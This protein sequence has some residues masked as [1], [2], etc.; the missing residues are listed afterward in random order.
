M[1]SLLIFCH[2]FMKYLRE[3]A[4]KVLFLVARPLRRGGGKG[5]GTKKKELFLKLENFVATKLEGGGG[6]L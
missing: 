5:L 1:I 2:I 3:A 6:R 4:K